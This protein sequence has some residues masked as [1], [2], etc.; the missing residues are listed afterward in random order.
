MHHPTDRIVHTTANALTTELHLA[1]NSECVGAVELKGA[2]CSS[3]G[4]VFALGVMGRRID[5]SW[6][7]Y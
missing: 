7:I 4:R 5:P 1:P 6:W 3:V 2:I